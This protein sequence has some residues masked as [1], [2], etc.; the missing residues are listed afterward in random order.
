MKPC[1]NFNING[2]SDDCE[3]A[4]KVIN[5]YMTCSRCQKLDNNQHQAIMSLKECINNT[6]FWYIDADSGLELLDAYE[7]AIIYNPLDEELS[8]HIYYFT[9]SNSEYHESFFITWTWKNQEEC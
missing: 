8:C 7:R 4:R 5:H 9:D 6:K 1:S 2:D 3:S